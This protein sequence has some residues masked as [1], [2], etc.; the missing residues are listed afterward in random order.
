MLNHDL[1]LT[2]HQI[3]TATSAIEA[4]PITSANIPATLR[5]TARGSEL[6]ESDASHHE[7]ISYILTDCF[8][9][10]GQGVKD[11]KT[12][13][14]SAIMW[15]HDRYR[16]KFLRTMHVFGN[17]WLQDRLRVKGVSRMLG[18]RAAYYAGDQPSIDLA[19]IKQA[20]AAVEKYCRL[21]AAR[22]FRAIGEPGDD[23][24]PVRHAGYWCEPMID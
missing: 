9:S 18:E 4:I 1:H 15:L 5:D 12:I 7:A 8:V 10:L 13:D 2:I 14:Q 19:N 17:T 6:A 22:R 11:A 23:S 20:A 3:P 24:A 16:A 21:H